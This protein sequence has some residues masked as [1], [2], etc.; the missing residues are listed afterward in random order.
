MNTYIAI[1]LFLIILIALYQVY[2]YVNPK[3]LVDS[4]VIKLN[5]SSK[6]DEYSQK[7]ILLE[8]T[9]DPSG[10]RYYYDGW[11]R[12]NHISNNDKN[13]ILFKRGHDFVV[14]LKGHELSI[15][16]LK[17]A[18]NITATEGTWTDP[19]FTLI[20]NITTNLPFQRWVYFCINVEGNQMDAYLNGKLTNSVK[21][22]D[23]TDKGNSP[24]TL[25][26]TT[27]AT[28]ESKIRVG[29]KYTTGSLARFRREPGNMDAQSVWNT[30]MLGPGVNDSGDDNNPEYH[31]K[32]SLLRNNKP[33][34]A[35]HFF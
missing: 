7:E 4:S 19:S 34:R 10:V 15:V 24:A 26:F 18:T 2:Y 1:F 17:A 23:I 13:L 14:S 21:G 20:T 16:D 8:E 12:I 25:D 29:N 35:F 3:L 11:V 9:E 32:I 22:K 6:L 30:F 28:A 33:R 31:A 5:E 27:Y